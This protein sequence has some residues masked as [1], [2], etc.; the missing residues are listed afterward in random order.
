F[1]VHRVDQQRL[2][3]FICRTREFTK[4]KNTAIALTRH[5]LFRY[6]V[7][8]I[9]DRCNESDVSRLVHRAKV[10]KGKVTVPVDDGLPF[11]RRVLS[12]YAAHDL[13]NHLLPLIILRYDL[14]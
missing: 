5:I 8:T 2:A 11:K 3:H 6:E 9:P 10:V 12:V 4:Y 1:L 7:H 14:A 13:L